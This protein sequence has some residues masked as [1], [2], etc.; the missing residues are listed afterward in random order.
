MTTIKNCRLAAG[1]VTDIQIEQGVIV[2]IGRP[3]SGGDE[4]DTRHGTVLPGVIDAHVHFREP[5]GEHKEDW[6]TGSAAAASGGVTT[7]LDMPN[8]NPP[9]V[10]EPSLAIKRERAQQSLVNYGFFLG[11]T[12]KNSEAIKTVRDVAGVKIYVGS[13]TGNLLVSEDD[14]IEKLFAIPSIQWVIHAEDESRIRENSRQ[15]G[16]S[17][18]PAAHSQIRDPQTAVE[19][20]RR[21]IALARKTNARIHIC[22][23]STKEEL[24]FIDAA[25]HE[26]VAI[27]CEVSPHHLFLNEAAYRMQFTF[28]KVNPPIRT[29]E[30]NAALIQGLA[31]GTIDIVA[32]D[33]A[34]HT[35]EEKNQHPIDAPSGMPEVE[36]SLPLLLNLVNHGG[37]TL[38]RLQQITAERPAELFR[39]RGKG[40]IAVGYDA[41]ITVVDMQKKQRVS[42]NMIRSKCGWSPYEGQMLT[43]WPVMTMVNGN[44]VYSNGTLNDRFK[45]KEVMYGKV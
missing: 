29:A 38:E 9:T 12:T 5:G 28:V 41:D 25:R 23:V 37:L 24:S 42:K 15:I 8:T 33:H 21:V 45:G 35:R 2:K 34:P 22:H 13:S 3:L 20:V 1:N 18:D 10:D 4:I 26:G 31:A 6:A 43:G 16:R 39:L 36:T 17:E 30:D 27:T 44:V 7:V 14:D 40:R 19:A 32:T 11:A